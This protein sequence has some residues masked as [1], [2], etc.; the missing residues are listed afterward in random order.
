MRPRSS[1][2]ARAPSAPRGARRCGCAIPSTPRSP[3]SERR[4]PGVVAVGRA[5]F[6][7]AAAGRA[8]ASALAR[9]R[10]G[11]A[12]GRPERCG[13]RLLR[14]RG[15]AEILD[16]AQPW[17]RRSA[18]CP[19]SSAVP[20]A[21]TRARRRV[22]ALINATLV[23]VLRSQA[24]RRLRLHPHVGQL[25]RMHEAAHREIPRPQHVLRR[26]RGAVPRAAP[27]RPWWS[28]LGARRAAPGR[29]WWSP[30]GARRAKGMATRHEESLL[31]AGPSKSHDRSP[32]FDAPHVNVALLPIRKSFFSVFGLERGRNSLWPAETRPVCRRHGL[33]PDIAYFPISRYNTPAI[34]HPE[35]DQR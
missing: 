12:R 15:P 7:G 14:G 32:T 23:V 13:G 2:R 21:R 10:G 24:R 34:H 6:P 26:V 33:E 35:R 22:D 8:A 4:R 5:R 30:S 9:L 28:R 17:R 18:P 16:Q 1:E 19:P 29:S 3:E 31:Q 27:T 20:C 25:A 11:A